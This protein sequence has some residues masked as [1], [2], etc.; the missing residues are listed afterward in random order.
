[1][2]D[3]TELEQLCGVLGP[4]AGVYAL[5][6]FPM[7]VELVPTAISDRDGNVIQVIE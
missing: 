3:E 5:P 2:N 1:M 7:T 4:Y 6:A